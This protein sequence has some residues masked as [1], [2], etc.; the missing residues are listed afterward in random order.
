V[1]VGGHR[2][3]V[4][5]VGILDQGVVAKYDTQRKAG[6]RVYLA[7]WRREHSQKDREPGLPAAIADPS[8]YS[9]H[10]KRKGKSRYENREQ[11]ALSQEGLVLSE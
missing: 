6:P 3:R 1:I 8:S 4:S 2:W 7:I 5:C 11:T 10:L 9:N